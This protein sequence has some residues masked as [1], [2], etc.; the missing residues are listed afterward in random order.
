MSPGPWKHASRTAYPLAN[1]SFYPARLSLA[2]HHPLTANSTLVKELRLTA[3]TMS[4]KQEKDSQNNNQN[5]QWLVVAT[6]TH[7]SPTPHI[8]LSDPSVDNL[9]L[10]LETLK[11]KHMLVSYLLNIQFSC[12]ETLIFSGCAHT[13]LTVSLI[14]DAG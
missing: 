1:D 10:W 12:C 7:K 9:N 3:R 11:S 6:T 8:S 2:L 13:L 5:G 14:T 4:E